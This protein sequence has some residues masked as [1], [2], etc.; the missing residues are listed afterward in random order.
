MQQNV[1]V[2]G[3]SLVSTCLFTQLHE[4]LHTNT[5]T[6]THCSPALTVTAST[7][8]S[9]Q[10]CV[11]IT[12]AKLVFLMSLSTVLY[13]TQAQTLSN[14]LQ[15]RTGDTV[16]QVRQSSLAVLGG[17]AGLGE[18]AVFCWLFFYIKQS[19]MNSSY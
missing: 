14:Q 8:C 2:N 13:Q 6:H 4:H 16:T 18:G 15:L 1:L 17:A 5:Q 10:E 11:P 7:N 9:L 19:T 12:S 3:T